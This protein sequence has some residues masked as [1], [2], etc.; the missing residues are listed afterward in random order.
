MEEETKNELISPY[1]LI[2]I[3]LALMF[4]IMSGIIIFILYF[5][6]IGVIISGIINFLGFTFFG[7]W[8]FFR[9][10]KIAKKDIRKKIAMKIIKRGGLSFLGSIIPFFGKLI[11]FWTI[12][13]YSE[14]KNG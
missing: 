3:M 9:S 13:V 11:P 2:M 5:L 7:T 14:L 6:G 1:G 12:A 8:I 4:D 10:K